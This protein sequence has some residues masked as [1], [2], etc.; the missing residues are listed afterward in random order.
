[1]ITTI[2]QY[3]KADLIDI[4]KVA[5]SSIFVFWKSSAIFVS[6]IAIIQLRL[7]SATSLLRKAKYIVEKDARIVQSIGIAAINTDLSLVQCCNLFISTEDYCTAVYDSTS[8]TCKLYGS[9]CC[10]LNTESSIGS[11]ILR[12]D[13][14]GKILRKS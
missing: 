11:L 14:S 12:K 8:G 5:M 1:M 4:I 9:E 13:R 3:G 6:L 7:L 2:I 10:S